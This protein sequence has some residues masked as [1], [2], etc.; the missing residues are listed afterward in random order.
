MDQKKAFKGGTE[1]EGEHNIIDQW[2]L[3]V[4]YPDL[5]GSQLQKPAFLTL[6]RGLTHGH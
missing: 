1:G 3:L 5:L 6:F 2:T 4:L